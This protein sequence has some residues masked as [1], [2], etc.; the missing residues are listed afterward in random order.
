M[1]VRLCA[2]V[3]TC[4]CVCV[5]SPTQALA[6]SPLGTYLLTWEKPSKEEASAE[7][8]RDWLTFWYVCICR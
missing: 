8:V 2:C 1:Q 7:E 3:R 5:C 6:F 4:V